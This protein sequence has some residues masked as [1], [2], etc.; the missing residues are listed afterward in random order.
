MASAGTRGGCNPR[1]RNAALDNTG[2]SREGVVGDA[3]GGKEKAVLSAAVFAWRWPWVLLEGPDRM[4][5]LPVSG[6]KCMECCVCVRVRVR[7]RASLVWLATAGGAF[8]GVEI[9]GVH[10]PF[11]GTE[12]VAG[13][14]ARG[15]WWHDKQRPPDD[16]NFGAGE[17]EDWDGAAGHAS[18]AL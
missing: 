3:G 8:S 13:I 9:E 4:C 15:S 7:G 1:A 17:D 5:R 12:S 16:C 2:K 11:A 10:A 18:S 6:R 14:R